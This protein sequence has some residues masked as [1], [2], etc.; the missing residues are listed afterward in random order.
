[1]LGYGVGRLLERTEARWASGRLL[2]ARPKIDQLVERFR[3][4]G[5]LYIAIN[6]FLPSV[7]A[8][9]FV[10]AGM[11][12]LSP[13]KVLAFGLLSALAWNAVLFAVGATAGQNWELLQRMF[14]TY[15]EVVWG[16]LACVALFLLGR[17]WRRRARAAS[18][19]R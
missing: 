9:F 11:A 6:R 5:A 15:S 14:L 4:H 12:R 13:W 1:M 8:L 7:R 17:W 18:N 3:R 16:L 2:R 19:A 10:A